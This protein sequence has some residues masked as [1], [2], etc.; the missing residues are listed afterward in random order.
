M[1]VITNGVV[2]YSHSPLICRPDGVINDVNLADAMLSVTDNT[3]VLPE[4]KLTNGGGN[5]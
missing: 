5:L 4:R 3:R 1:E 2:I